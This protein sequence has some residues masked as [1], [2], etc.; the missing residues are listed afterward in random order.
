MHGTMSLKFSYAQLYL[1]GRLVSKFLDVFTGKKFQTGKFLA[2]ILG[3]H[4]SNPGQENDYR[5]N[6][7]CFYSACPENFRR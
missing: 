6:I 4:G 7:L 2:Y 1:F 3:A 5:K